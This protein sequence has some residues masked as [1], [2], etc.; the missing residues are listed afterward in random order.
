[1]YASP[2]KEGCL[3]VVG[4]LAQDGSDN[5]DGET[6]SKTPNDT[7]QYQDDLCEESVWRVSAE[8]RATRRFRKEEGS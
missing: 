8:E 5:R 6:L 2:A 3:H 1:V 7:N 4:H